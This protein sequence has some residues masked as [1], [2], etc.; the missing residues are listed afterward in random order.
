[1]VAETQTPSP[2]ELKRLGFVQQYA[3]TV[4]GGAATVEQVYRERV[5]PLVPKQVEPYV[6][7][8]EDTVVAYAA[9]ALAAASDTAEK[10]L[11]QTDEQ[12]GCDRQSRPPAATHGTGDG[13]S[14]LG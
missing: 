10:L 6:V 8:A 12:V 13:Q 1:M 3:K 2:A 4:A 14:S 5:R 7:R 11:K 9:P